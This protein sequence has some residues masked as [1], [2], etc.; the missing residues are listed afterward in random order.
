MTLI[1]VPV[2]NCCDQDEIL[3]PNVHYTNV[4]KPAFDFSVAFTILPI[5]LTFP[6]ILERLMHSTGYGRPVVNALSK[7]RE[8]TLLYQGP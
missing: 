6:G 2:L 7:A 1:V 5:S 8:S 3:A 4:W